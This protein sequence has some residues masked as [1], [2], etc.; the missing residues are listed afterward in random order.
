VNN[1]TRKPS[2]K[3]IYVSDPYGPNPYDEQYSCQEA[4]NT[5]HDSTGVR[6]NDRYDKYCDEL[7][8]ELLDEEEGEDGAAG[9][10]TER[11]DRIGDET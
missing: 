7:C 6:S 1:I 10:T 8:D 9:T 3:E 4:T 11:E 5:R 2:R